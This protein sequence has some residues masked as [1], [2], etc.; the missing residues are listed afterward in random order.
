LHNEIK[1]HAKFLAKW[2]LFSILDFALRGKKPKRTSR[3][4]NKGNKFCILDETKYNFKSFDILH[5][6][7]LK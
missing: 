6:V 3:G 1:Y 5:F 7:I 2:W 4:H